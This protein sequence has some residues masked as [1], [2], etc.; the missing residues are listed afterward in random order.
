[1]GIS[2][3]RAG[4]AER[5]ST[6]VAFACALVLGLAIVTEF[7]KETSGPAPLDA[8]DGRIVPP[9]VVLSAVVIGAIASVVAVVLSVDRHRALGQA[10]S[11]KRQ[12]LRASGMVL[13]AGVTA[14][15]WAFH[16]GMYLFFRDWTF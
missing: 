14:G 12:A 6:L 13:I 11:V 2:S 10:E 15:A 8:G 5:I 16:Y 9:D 7:L 4:R 1:M 3:T